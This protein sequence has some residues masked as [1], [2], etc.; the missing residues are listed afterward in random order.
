MGMVLFWPMW[1]R[2]IKFWPEGRGEAAGERLHA[3]VSPGEERLP[4]T[5]H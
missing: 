3:G 2:L 1:W 5:Q 4:C